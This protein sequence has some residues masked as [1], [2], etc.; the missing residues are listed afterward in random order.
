[1]AKKNKTGIMEYVWIAVAVLS[2][3]TGIH[4]TIKYGFNESYLFFIFAAISILLFF[5]RRYL[6]KNMK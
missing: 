2:L 3:V 4:K 5:Y 6:R 1:M